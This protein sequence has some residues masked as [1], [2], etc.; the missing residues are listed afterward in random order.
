[1]TPQASYGSGADTIPE[2]HYRLLQTNEVEAAHQLE[3]A[4]FTPEA[5]ATLEA[6]RFRQLNFPCYF[7]S[8]WSEDHLIG[9]ACAIR[10]AESACEENEVKGSHEP[11]RDGMN[12]CVLSVA[13]EPDHRLQGVG[14]ALMK[15][16]VKQALNDHLESVYLMCEEHLIPFYKKHG[17][18]YIGLSS[19]NHGGLQWHEMKLVLSE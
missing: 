6:F 11:Q 17:F 8:A 7:W 12:L 9:L 3:M 15:P 2:Y 13:V 14:D 5:A 1:M 18:K 16:L 19:S 10:T 4:C